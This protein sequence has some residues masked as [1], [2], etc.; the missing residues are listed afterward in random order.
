MYYQLG[1]QERCSRGQKRIEEK[2][3]VALLGHEGGGNL[4]RD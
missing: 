2:D 3:V 1:K 4:A